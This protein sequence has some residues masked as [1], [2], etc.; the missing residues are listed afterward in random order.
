MIVT[1][2]EF[3]KGKEPAGVCASFRKVFKA[4]NPEGPF[5]TEELLSITLQHHNS[6]LVLCALKMPEGKLVGCA[7]LHVRQSVNRRRATVENVVVKTTAQGQGLGKALMERLI[8]EAQRRNV[9]T[10]DLTSKRTRAVARAIYEEFGFKRVDTDVFR[11]D[12]RRNP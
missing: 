2:Q 11:F 10:I 4:L 7:E 1:L 5:P 3:I 9:E 6:V 12:L 8:W